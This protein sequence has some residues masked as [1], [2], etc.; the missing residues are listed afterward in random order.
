[1]KPPIDTQKELSKIAG[2]SHDTI[3]KV[4]QIEEKATSEQ[5]AKLQTGE[6][7]INEV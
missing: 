3:A 7:S 2:V 4:K 6:V 5:K 1:V